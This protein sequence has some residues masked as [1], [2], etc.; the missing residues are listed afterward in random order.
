MDNRFPKMVRFLVQKLDFLA[1]P[2]LGLLLAGLAVLGFVGQVLLQAPI[3]K[4]IF[5]PVRVLQ[6]EWWRLLTFPLSEA[7][8]NPIWLLF[9][10][11]YVYFIMNALEGTWGPDLS[12]F[13]H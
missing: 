6:G 2:N 10:C 1:I 9:Y 8:S 3:E 12:Q 13:S 5:D 7:P 11:F 4:F